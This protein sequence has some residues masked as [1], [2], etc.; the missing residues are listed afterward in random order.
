MGRIPQTKVHDKRSTLAFHYTLTAIILNYDI[1]SVTI[2]HF[3]IFFKNV[4]TR[5][6][7]NT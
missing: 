6:I 1:L 2:L 7:R 3:I 4:T 5:V